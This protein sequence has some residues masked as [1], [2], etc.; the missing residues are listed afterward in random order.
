MPTAIR[1]DNVW[2]KYTLQKD[3]PTSFHHA[4][5]ILFP[6]LRHHRIQFDAI[7]DLSFEISQGEAVGFIGNNGA[8]K[9][10]LLKLMA[11][12]QI[13]DKGSVTIHGSVAALLE[14]GAGF[15]FE[16][17]G[18]E[19][20]RLNGPLM[21]LSSSQVEEKTEE[22]IRF[23]ELD[24]FIDSPLKTYSSGMVLRLGFSIAAHL[25]ADI[26]LI[27]EVLSVGDESF[28]RKCYRK[29][30]QFRDEGKTLVLCSHSMNSISQICS[31]VNLVQ[32]GKI[33]NSG[34]P[35]KVISFYMKTT[36][37]RQGLTVLQAGESSTIFNNGRISMFHKGEEITTNIGIYSELWVENLTRRSYHADWKIE[38]TTDSS[39][40]VHGRYHSTPAKWI[41]KLN[42]SEGVLSLEFILETTKTLTFQGAILDGIFHNDYDSWW[43]DNETG[44]L[45]PIHL[46]GNDWSQLAALKLEGDRIG[47]A[48]SGN[49]EK[50]VVELDFSGMGSEVSEEKIVRVFNT[51]YEMFGRVLR[52][53]NSNLSNQ[54][55]PLEPGNR[56]FF[57]GNVRLRETSAQEWL[58]PI[59]EKQSLSQD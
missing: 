27:D 34:S 14:L 57:R 37:E 10:T 28:Q 18:R 21:G 46:F 55:K 35:G 33:I 45:P 52:F 12:I 32:K 3:K 2:V 13:P 25:P 7:Q 9:S 39:C 15:H 23:S 53:Q 36:G 48:S 4:L 51:Q 1:F 50:P 24:D 20:I 30:R 19:N 5:Q 8:G 54:S 43:T 47:L 22:I 41:W 31:R 56:I 40:E 17:T 38:K 26:L 11:G 44:R 29:I 42:L 6:H 58:A 16:L 49:R 59:A